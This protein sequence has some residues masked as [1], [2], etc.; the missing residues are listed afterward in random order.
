MLSTTLYSACTIMEIIMGS[1]MLN[2]SLPTGITP[3][4]FSCNTGAFVL[5]SILVFYSPPYD[6]HF[7]SIIGEVP[8]FCKKNS[9]PYSIFVIY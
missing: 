9:Y 7:R 8:F 3:I 5:L 1:A 2:S 4:L 6:S